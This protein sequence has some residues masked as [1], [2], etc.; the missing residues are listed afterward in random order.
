MIILI[1]N[2]NLINSKCFKCKTSITGITYNVDARITIKEG[3]VV[4]N[5]TYDA[6]KS[7]KKEVEI[8]VPLTLFYIGAVA[9]MPPPL[10]F[11]LISS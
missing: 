5:A 3:N 1:Q 7:C 11:F 8:A 6:N 4:N 10:G 9:K 2:K